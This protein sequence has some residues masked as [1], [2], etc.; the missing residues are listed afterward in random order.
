MLVRIPSRPKLA[1]LK[2]RALRKASRMLFTHGWAYFLRRGYSMDD[3]VVFINVPRV[4]VELTNLIAEYGE[5]EEMLSKARFTTLQQLAERADSAVRVM[6]TAL[7]GPQYGYESTE[8]GT[9]IARDE[10]GNPI[11]LS[12]EPTPIQL[13]AAM[14]TLRL[15]GIRPEPVMSA[16]VD[17]PDK[18]SKPVDA[19][20]IEQAMT[21]EGDASEQA[22]S[23]ERV[24]A[25]VG[26]KI[27]ELTCHVTPQK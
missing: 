4:Q 22:M 11:I 17:M 12:P 25:T 7:K 5:H 20:I 15:L 2:L 19:K 9:A 13:K 21:I 16:R 1:N 27:K 18:P 23:R 8:H 26:A 14:E 3:V 10:A 24:L 6:V